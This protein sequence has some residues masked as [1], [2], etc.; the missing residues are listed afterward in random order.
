VH[1]ASGTW[2]LRSKKLKDDRDCSI[3]FQN[4]DLRKVLD[5]WNCM[6]I[7]KFGRIF[8]EGGEE[9][10]GGFSGEGSWPLFRKVK[11]E[12][13]SSSESIFENPSNLGGAK[14]P[15]PQKAFWSDSL[16]TVRDRHAGGRAKN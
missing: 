12:A 1:V 15:S 7:S 8:K 14:K 9:D 10:S 13:F 5:Q 11:S 3:C 16:E 4:L 6:K 2:G